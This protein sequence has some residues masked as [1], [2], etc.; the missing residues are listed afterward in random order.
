MLTGRDAHVEDDLPPSG[1]KPRFRSNHSPNLR[2][3]SRGDGRMAFSEA[4]DGAD[5]RPSGWCCYNALER[6]VLKGSGQV[7]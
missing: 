5:D 3:F 7:Q 1:M 6:P 4:V 2:I